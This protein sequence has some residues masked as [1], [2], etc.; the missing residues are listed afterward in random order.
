MPSTIMR[1]LK[2]Q[3]PIR[4]ITLFL[5]PFIFMITINEAVRPTIQEKPYQLFGMATINSANQLENKC[6]WNCYT[7]TPYCKAHHVKFNKKYFAL[8]DPLYFGLINLLKMGGNYALANI[9][10]LILLVPFCIW[11]FL[12][13]ALNIRDEI[14]QLKRHE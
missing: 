7:N 8:T 3:K 14:Q 6:T 13:K 4:N 12:I 2:M 9:V 10:F 11:Y 5:L 1:Y